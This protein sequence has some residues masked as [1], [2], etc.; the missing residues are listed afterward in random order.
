MLVGEWSGDGDH[1]MR[2]MRTGIL[3]ANEQRLEAALEAAE[4]DQPS[5]R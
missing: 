3:A 4:P 5:Q 1:R 2:S